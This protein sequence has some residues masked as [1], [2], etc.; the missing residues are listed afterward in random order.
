[1][2]EQGKIGSLQ[3][4]FLLVNMVLPTA[5]LFVA[6][7]TAHLAGQDGWISLLLAVLAA[8]VVARLAVSLGRRFPGQTL[9]QFPEQILG[10]WPGK[11]VAVLYI[12]W[13]FHMNAEI[14]RQ[15]GS[16]LV[17][18]FMPQTPLIVFELLIVVVAAYAVR[19]GLE[20]F[21]RVSQVIFPLI[22]GLAII[23]CILVAPEM[24]LKRLLPVFSD[25][26]TVPVLKGAV[27]PAAWMGEIVTVAVLLPYLNRAQEAFKVAVT[28]TLITGLMLLLSFVVNIALFGPEV[29]DGWLFPDL[30]RVRIISLANF[31]E[32]LE[33]ITMAVWVAG[34]LVKIS[35]F[36]WAAVLGSAQCLGLKDYRPLVLPAGVILLALSVM[37]HDSTID[38][39]NFLSTFWGPY[40][41]SLFQAGIPF[42]LLAVAAVRGLGVKQ[43]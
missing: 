40:A 22:L 24:D 16:F 31:I 4:V 25:S 27:M 26:G 36:Y 15:F 6:T 5:F 8:L 29:A 35:I 38:L 37:L 39:F 17:V 1:M 2:L 19:G 21:A 43:K 12:W 11:A 13:Y 9:F 20:V 34:G 28:A 10:R 32:R 42:F 18:A 7:H 23:T 41:L 33:A 3:A 14:I 30:D